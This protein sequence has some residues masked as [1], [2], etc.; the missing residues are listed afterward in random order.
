MPASAC[1]EGL[2]EVILIGFTAVV[3]VFI[4]TA[5]SQSGLIRLRKKHTLSGLG[6]WTMASLSTLHLIAGFGLLCIGRSTGPLG[7]VITF[8]LAVPLLL[9]SRAGFRNPRSRSQ[10]AV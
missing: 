3:S 6:R 1:V 10:K 8:L 5:V 4:F 7:T 2:F 9:L